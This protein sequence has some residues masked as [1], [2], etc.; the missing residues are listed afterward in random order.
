MSAAFRKR[1]NPKKVVRRIVFLLLIA[2][3]VFNFGNI[4]RFLNPF[5]YQELTYSYAQQYQVDPFLI[6]AIIKTESNFNPEAVSAKGARGL[7]QIMPETGSWIAQQTGEPSVKL[8]DL[9]DPETNIKLGTWYVANLEEEFPDDIVLVLAAYNGG[10]GN[11]RDW[12]EQKIFS[13]EAEK[14]EEIPFSETRYFVKKVLIYQHL[15]RYLY[16]E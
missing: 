6:A 2:F 3:T 4:A 8:E 10:R 14:V 7:M 1:T 9:F 15:Y 16:G 12:L 11:V 5:P 13:G